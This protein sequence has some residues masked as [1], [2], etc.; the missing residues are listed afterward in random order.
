MVE[1]LAAH[2]DKL[3]D[4]A[5][6]RQ[7]DFAL[8][9]LAVETAVARHAG[10]IEQTYTPVGLTYVQT[11]K[12]LSDVRR[13]IATGGALIHAPRPEEAVRH[14]LWSPADPISLRPKQ[15]QV[16]VDRHYILAAMGLLAEHYPKAALQMMKRE[17]TCD[18]NS[19]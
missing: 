10:T 18:G 13:I 15:A 7:L 8:A 19:K 16:W 9:S 17:L 12:D 6:G 1:D 3:P 14:A 11:G 2:T 4:S 5:A